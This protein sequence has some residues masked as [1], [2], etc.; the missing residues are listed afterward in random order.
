MH[1]HDKSRSQEDA[2]ESRRRTGT[3]AGS[4]RTPVRPADMLLG[5]QRSV[6][7][8]AVAGMVTGLQRMEDP[9]DT[10]PHPVQ[11]SA[12]HEALASGGRPLDEPIRTEMESRL[13]ADF[14]D[15]RVHTDSVAQRS[16]TEIGAR[17]YTS[18]NHVVVGQGGGDKHIL[19]HELVHVIQQR[20]GPVAG[21]DRGDGLSISDPGDTFERE[22]EDVATKAL[23]GPAHETPGHTH[24]PGDAVQRMADA[25]PAGTQVQR[26]NGHGQALNSP[27]LNG[28]QVLLSIINGQTQVAHGQRATGQHVAILQ[29][30]LNAVTRRR[31]TVDGVFGH[32]TIEAVNDFQGRQGMWGTGVVD[33]TTLARLDQVLSAHAPAQQPAP[34]GAQG[35]AVPGGVAAVGQQGA[36]SSQ[37]T[38]TRRID[39]NGPAYE[40]RI[41]QA[42]IDQIDEDYR[43]VVL[44]RPARTEDNLMQVP[45][46]DRVAAAAKQVTDAVFGN[47]SVGEPLEYGDNVR[48]LFEVRGAQLGV[49]GG[50]TRA[51]N[52]E[53]RRILEGDVVREIDRQHGAVQNGAAESALLLPFIDRVTQERFG[54]LL[55]IYQHWPGVE[56]EGINIQRFW[57]RNRNPQEDRNKLYHLFGTMIHEYLHGLEHDDYQDFYESAEGPQQKVL[58]EGMTDY[59]A[60]MVWD[61]LTFDPALRQ[62]IEGPLYDPAAAAGSIPEP[63]RYAELADA[64]QLVNTIGAQFAAEAYF[65]GR[66]DRLP[67]L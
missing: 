39:P 57:D 34:A 53:I 6:G 28:D 48:D 61:G 51:A 17:A 67:G 25:T 4:S 35:P 36:G 30:A 1:F 38:F 54:Q 59:W 58:S 49:A 12:V 7:N 20:Q 18:G 37:S 62:S 33:Q 24:G 56:D 45:D 47:F 65:H 9:A 41:Y 44:D 13:G 26:V 3:P 14:S 42:L 46:I 50:G 21:T 19:A 11:R 16:A 60:K 23:S 8:A 64:A 15:V 55:A 40:E 31:L 32:R 2:A 10:G 52:E 27:L 63:P 22:A 5:L 43:D 66:T 29:Q